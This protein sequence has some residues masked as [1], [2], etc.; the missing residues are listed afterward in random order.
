MGLG[1][2]HT[3]VEPAHGVMILMQFRDVAT[4]LPLIQQNVHPGMCMCITQD[5]KPSFSEAPPNSKPL[6][7]LRY[8][9]YWS[10]P[11]YLWFFYLHMV[12]KFCEQV[13]LWLLLSDANCCRIHLLHRNKGIAKIMQHSLNMRVLKQFAFSYMGFANC[14][15]L[16]LTKI[17]LPLHEYVE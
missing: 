10:A 9:Y 1:L 7:K 4:L 13:E 11:V 16:L 5:R 12:Y 3:S 2:V 6:N 14:L 8:G 17:T 15:I